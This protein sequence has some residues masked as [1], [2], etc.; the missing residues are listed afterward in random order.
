MKNKKN[1]AIAFLSTLIIFQTLKPMDHSLELYNAVLK[2][3]QSPGRDIVAV[4]QHIEQGGNPN[5]YVTQS[6]SETLLFAATKAGREDLTR[7]LLQADADPDKARK[8]GVTPL[9]QSIRAE[10]T[11]IAAILLEH[12]ADPEKADVDGTPLIHAVTLDLENVVMALLNKGA[13]VRKAHAEIANTLG[14][15][16]IRDCL[17]EWGALEKPPKKDKAD[18]ARSIAREIETIERLRTELKRLPKSQRRRKRRRKKDACIKPYKSERAEF[19]A[20]SKRRERLQK[21]VRQRKSS[22]KISQLPSANVSSECSICY[23]T[24]QSI[25][26]IQ[27]NTEERYC[28]NKHTDAMCTTCLRECETCPF[29]NQNLITQTLSLD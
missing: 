7:L 28:I 6:D 21:R 29:C 2:A 19:I 16:I 24:G 23:K 10:R 14:Y 12:N 3:I 13:S 25:E 5:K 8:D 27:G 22:L 17:I 11:D 20:L 1:L 15:E 9:T 18:I 26:L 4:K